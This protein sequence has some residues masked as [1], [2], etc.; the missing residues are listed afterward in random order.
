M[1]MEKINQFNRFYV[2]HGKKA[3]KYVSNILDFNFTS[4]FIINNCV[5]LLGVNALEM[6]IILSFINSYISIT[7]DSHTNAQSSISTTTKTY[8]RTPDCWTSKL[9]PFMF[10]F[11]IQ[12]FLDERKNLFYFPLIV[13]KFFCFFLG[14]KKKKQNNTLSLDVSYLCCFHGCCSG[15]LFGV[16]A[17]VLAKCGQTSLGAT[18]QDSL[19]ILVHLQLD[20]DTLQLEWVKEWNQW[21]VRANMIWYDGSGRQTL[22]YC[23]GHEHVYVCMRLTPTICIK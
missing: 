10:F 12:F 20:D 17:L 9:K 22:C 18:F 6:S 3:E 21:N 8:K 15:G 7:I 23:L 2:V 19:A 13:F 16:F 11:F 1:N 14:F 4:N 5:L